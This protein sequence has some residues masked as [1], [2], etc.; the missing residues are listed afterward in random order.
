M[1][2]LKFFLMGTIFFMILALNPIVNSQYPTYKCAAVLGGEKVLKVTK[3]DPA[4]LTITMGDIPPYD[5][6]TE[7]QNSFGMG[8]NVTGARNKA[9]I[10][11]VYPNETVSLGAG[12]MNAFKVETKYWLWTTEDFASTPD[13]AAVNVTTLYNPTDLQTLCALGY[14]LPG[15][16]FV[17]GTNV[18]MYAIWWDGVNFITRAAATYLTQLPVDA[19]DY[20]AAMIWAENWTVDGLKVIYHGTPDIYGTFIN[21]YTAT[22]EFDNVYGAFIRYTLQDNESKVIYEFKVEL[23]EKGLIPGIQI[24]LLLGVSLASIITVIYIIMKKK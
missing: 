15:P 9:E 18:S 16:V 7:L 13:E 8:C 2:K 11:G 4:G 19:A 22:W 5:W 1:K 20:L 3:V 24:P 21:D 14:Y 17:P 6:S 23:P 10:I 12:P